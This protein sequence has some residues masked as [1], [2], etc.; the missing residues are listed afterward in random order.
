M[1]STHYVHTP[2]PFLFQWSEN[3]GIRYYGLAYLL[4]FLAVYFGMTWFYKRQ[5]S[6][7]KPDHVGDLLTWCIVGTLVGGRLAYCFLYDFQATIHDPISIIAF[8]RGGIS[9]MASHGG[10]AGVIVAAAWYAHRN[11]YSLWPVYDNL[12]IW[13]TPGLFLGRIANFINGELW[14]RPTDVSWGV[15][16]N[17]SD[18]PW[19]R[20][21]NVPR[22][23]S[24]LYEAFGE[25]L[26]L[27]LVL[28]FLK[29]KGVKTGMISG[30][31]LSGYGLMR[32]LCEQFREPD[33][34]IGY[35]P[36]GFTQGQLLSTLPI[37]AGGVIWV[38]A[39]RG[40]FKSS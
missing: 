22:H 21:E 1:F 7:V 29:W 11:G 40:K 6:S 4:G 10:F 25:G 37:L 24:Q 26:F 14:G 31:F 28:L 34:H 27:F 18:V 38:M 16:F 32:I 8:W 12:S 33:S 39:Y 36:G 23:P 17:V 30:V 15:I 3:W 19:I 5:W 13:A 20:G 9:G 2:N 35:Y